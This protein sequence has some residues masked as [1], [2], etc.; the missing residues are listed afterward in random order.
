M[1]KETWLMSEVGGMLGGM[2]RDKR[3]NDRRMMVEG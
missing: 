1:L 2:T 3:R